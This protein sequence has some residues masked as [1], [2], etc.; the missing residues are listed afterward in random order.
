ML[1]GVSENIEA[2]RRALHTDYQEELGNVANPG[3]SCATEE[4]SE[5][6]ELLSGIECNSHD[7]MTLLVGGQNESLREGEAEL[8]K[9]RQADG[10]LDR[11]PEETAEREY[12]M[13]LDIT[14]YELQ[15]LER[16]AE[17]ELLNEASCM[18]EVKVYIHHIGG[19]SSIWPPGMILKGEGLLARSVKALFKI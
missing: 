7:F 4:K 2:L 12:L 15:L 16:Q 13:S 1:A 11:A 18:S 10:A 3:T 8:N 5:S 19:N 9:K 17:E 14:E 6:S